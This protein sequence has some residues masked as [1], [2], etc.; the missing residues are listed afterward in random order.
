MK[1]KE[2][3]GFHRPVGVCLGQKPHLAPTLF[4]GRDSERER[5]AE[6]LRPVQGL[7]KQ[8]RLVLGGMGGV[9]KTQLAITYAGTQPSYYSS[10]FWLNAASDAALNA[11]FQSIASLIFDVEDTR[12]LESKE[13][14]RRVHQWLS[15]SRNTGWLLVFDNYDDP[16]QFD[17]N[18][19][20][21]PAS[22]GSILITTR[23]PDSVAG[24]KLHVKPFKDISHGL[25]ILQTRSERQNI[26][27]GMIPINALQDHLTNGI[28]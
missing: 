2:D 10:V 11:S 25:E 20:Y 26:Q 6:I 7:Q 13:I 27:S 14:I 8:R 16:G 28:R 17:I 1:Q 19:C 23:L 18:D 21:P 3:F 24:E 15:D 9:G 22:H 5:I 12:L 4:V